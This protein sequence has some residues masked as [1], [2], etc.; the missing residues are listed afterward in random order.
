MI[1]SLRATDLPDLLALLHWMDDAPEREVFAPDSRD[2]RELQLECEDSV[3]LVDDGEDGVQA[4]CALSPFRDGLVLEG[5]VGEGGNLRALLAQ[6]SRHT[7]GLPVY[8]FCA[9]DNQPVRDALEAAGFAP[10]HS[11]AFYAAPL[12]RVRAAAVPPDCEVVHALPIAEYRALF[13][14]AEDAWSGRLD[15]TPEQYDAH[16]ADEDV[17]LI[18]LQ[19]GRR[20]LAFVELE[21]NPEQARADVTYLAVHPAERGQGLGRALLALAAAEA[22]IH[23]EIRTLRVRAHDHMRPARTLY[24]RSGFTHC[25]SIVTYLRDGEEEA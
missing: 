22:R 20:P 17:R 8:A 23:L 18:A 5:P 6:A 14:A 19:R 15:W 21:F 7:D 9:R 4:Y 3:C 13:R 24:A 10:M 2:V 25:R 16:F 11:T 1:R 12:D